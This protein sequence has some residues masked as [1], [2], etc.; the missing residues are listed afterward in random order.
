MW[1]H[2]QSWAERQP[3]ELD[4]AL[5]HKHMKAVAKLSVAS[6]VAIAS[7]VIKGKL[8]AVML[9]TEGVGVLSQLKYLSNLFQFIFGMG[10]FKWF[11]TPC[12]KSSKRR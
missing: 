12:C 7:Q 1:L 6:F 2:I 8:G 9:G 10:F 3:V 5:E 11:D 4:L